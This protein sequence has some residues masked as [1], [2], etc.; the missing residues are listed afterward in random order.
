MANAFRS[1]FGKDDN[2]TFIALSI[3]H[4]KN[5]IKTDPAI[6]LLIISLGILLTASSGSWDITNH[7]LNRPETFFSPPHAGLYSGV[8]LVLFGSLMTYRYHR[9]SSKISDIKNKKSLPTYLRLVIVGIIMLISAGPLDF[10]WHTAFGLDGLLSPPHAVLTMGLVLCSIGAFLGLISKDNYYGRMRT[11]TNMKTMTNDDNYFIVGLKNASRNDTTTRTKRSLLYI[12]IAI[13][14]I[15]ITVSGII[16][17]VSLPFSDTDYFKFNPNPLLAGLIATLCFPFLVSFILFTSWEI[18][19]KFGMLSA[20]GMVFIFINLA[21][22]ILP[23]ENLV[24]MIPF[25]LL[26]VIP[27]ILI[28]VLLSLPA[29]GISSPILLSQTRKKIVKMLAGIVLG[30]TFFM[31]YFPLITHTYNEVSINPQPVWPSV[32][33]LIYFEMIDEMFPLLV[34]SS[35]AAG[36]LGVVV[37]S[38]LTTLALHDIHGITR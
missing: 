4:L 20:S 28:D 11:K 32:T 37:S 36:I 7:L 22:T 23:N 12:I 24:P 14:A 6:P 29:L 25:Y 27:I 18:T 19:K 3:S 10:A 34:V 31:L 35:M 2:N 8:V 38:K 9:H 33:A 16:H 15:W 1:L 21:T 17:M 13:T 26:N 30:L 5:S